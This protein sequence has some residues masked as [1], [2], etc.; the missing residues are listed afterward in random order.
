MSFSHQQKKEIIDQLALD[1]LNAEKSLGGRLLFALFLTRD[2][3]NMQANYLI[4][5]QN[6]RNMRADES[7]RA[8][9]VGQHDKRRFSRQGTQKRGSFV[10][11]E[12][13]EAIGRYYLRLD[14]RRKAQFVV[15][16]LNDDGKRYL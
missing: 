12:D 6:S 13:A 3:R 9:G 10:V 8:V 7:A 1:T 16:S 14:D 11:F 15:L 5:R 4:L 2:L